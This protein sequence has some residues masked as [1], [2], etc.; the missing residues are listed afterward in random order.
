MSSL[1]FCGSLW[2][3]RPG[4]HKA[5]PIHIKKE[6]TKKAEPTEDV[7]LYQGTSIGVE[8]AGIGSYLLG[9]DILNS[10]VSIQANFKNRFLPVVEVGYGKADTTKPQRLISGWEWIT[11]YFT[12]SRTFLATCS[13]DSVM[14]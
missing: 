3:Q 10:E 14:A 2:A 6:E 4:A 12:R 5:Q 1:L 13:W 9:S 8:I 11:T 7:P